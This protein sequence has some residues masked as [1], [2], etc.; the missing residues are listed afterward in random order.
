MTITTERLKK[1]VLPHTHTEWHDDY[2][3]VQQTQASPNNY[4]LA[5]C[6]FNW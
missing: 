1:V 3:E 5:H 2:L 6:I 4:T